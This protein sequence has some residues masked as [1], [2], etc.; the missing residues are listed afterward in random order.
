MLLLCLACQDYKLHGEG[1][2]PG[3]TDDSGW[4]EDDTSDPEGEICDVGAEAIEVGVTDTCVPHEG[5]FTPIVEWE[6]SGTGCTAL[7]VVGDLDGDG[8]PEILVNESFV[9]GTGTLHALHGDGSGSLWSVNAQAGYG[10]SPALGDIDDDGLPEIAIIREYESN[11]FADGD[12]TVVLY[13]GEGNELWESDHFIGLDFNYAGAPVISDMDHDGIP[14][15]VAGRVI[16]DGLTGGTRGVGEYGHGSFGIIGFGDYIMSE[17]SMAAVSDLDL[18]GEEEVIVGNAIYEID[19]EAI[20][21][22]ASQSDGMVAVANFDSDPEGEFVAVSNNTYRLHDTDGSIIW[23]PET[24]PSG[25][26]LSVPAIADIDLDGEP[27]ILVAGGNELR[28]VNADGSLLWRATVKDESGATGAS[29]FDFDGDGEPEVVYIDEIEMAAYDGITGAQEFY[30][31]DHAS[32]TMYD[33]PVIADVDADDQAE[34][35]VCH[36]G[37][38]SMMSVYGDQDESWPP[39]RQL[40]NQHAYSISNINDDLSVPE[41]ATPNFQHTNTWHS[42]I[43]TE[44]YGLTDDLEAEIVEICED[45]CDAGVVYVVV[46]LY[47]KGSEEI[48]AGV[49]MTLYGEAGAYRYALSTIETTDAIPSGWSTEGFE[50]ELYSDQ[51]TSMDGLVLVADDDGTGTGAIAECSES[52]NDYVR[53]GPFCTD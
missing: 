40:W 52:N 30:S 41:T 42:A 34:I 49:K 8:M 6:E 25:N 22:D 10:A 43:A 20:W 46:R 18:D 51:L 5:G 33:Y 53:S 35:V 29:V 47:N 17:G 39:A 3:G 37:Y 4:S 16:L 21:S 1:D 26:I 9:M 36:N 48:A 24:I 11:M 7:P 28:A 19:G 44:G 15:I 31:S 45:E 38:S 32:G 12:Y 50:I 23:G 14:E 2:V 13:S 27:E